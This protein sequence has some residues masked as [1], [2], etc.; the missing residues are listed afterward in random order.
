[1]SAL[2][3]VPLL[4]TK[5]QR[6]S[7]D[8]SNC[9]VCQTNTKERFAKPTERG[10]SSLTQVASSRK[11]HVYSR[12]WPDIENIQH[13]D[14]KWHPSCYASYTLKTYKEK[15]SPPSLSTPVLPRYVPQTRLSSNHPTRFNPEL[16]VICQRDRSH[17]SKA[18]TNKLVQVQTESGASRLEAAANRRQDEVFMRINGINL[19]KEQVKYHPYCRSAYVSERNITCATK[20]LFERGSGDGDNDDVFNNTLELLM[21]EISEPLRSGAALELSDVRARFNDLLHKADQDKPGNIDNRQLKTLLLRRFGDQLAFQ[22]PFSSSSSQLLYDRSVQQADVVNVVCQLTQ[23]QEDSSAHEELSPTQTVDSK[24]D[25]STSAAVLHAALAVKSDLRNLRQKNLQSEKVDLEEAAKF[26]PDSLYCLLKSILSDDDDD[27]QDPDADLHRAILNIGQDIAYQAS[28]RRLAPAKHVGIALAV[29]QATRSKTLVQ[30]LHAAGHCICYEQMQRIDTS[31]AKRQMCRFEE[32]QVTVSSN[33]TPGNFVQ[34]AADN[35]D[36][37]EKTLDGK[38]TFHA[39]QMAVF[40]NGSLDQAATTA[41][42]PS[43]GRKRVLKDVPEGF[44]DI[45]PA[46]MES[47]SKKLQPSFPPAGEL[48]ELCRVGQFN[49]HD[50]AWLVSRNLHHNHQV[51]PA[52][53]AYNQQMTAV[54]DTTKTVIGHMPIIRAPAH[55]F[56]TVWTVILRAKRVSQFLGQV[57]TVI[58]FDQA[59]YYKAKELTWLR[60]EECTKVIIRLGGFHTALNFLRCIGQHYADSG[61]KDIWMDSGLYSDCTAGKILEGKHWKRAVRAH[62]LTFE[63]LWRCLWPKLAECYPADKAATKALESIVT[64]FEKKDVQAATSLL[65]QVTTHMIQLAQH[66]AHFEDGCPENAM[67]V[68]WMQYMRMVSTLLS[69]IRAER[70]GNWSLHLSS[71]AEMLP[72]FSVYDHTN[73]ARWAPVYLLDMQ[74]LPT[75][76]PEVNMQFQAGNFGVRESTKPFSSL[77]TDQAL[78]HIN[79][80]GK[81]AGGLVGITKTDSALDRWSLTYT[82]R[83]HLADS[84]YKMLGVRIDPEGW[85]HVESGATR[86]KR[87]EE[88]VQKLVDELTLQCIFQTSGT[89]LI[90]LATKDVATPDITDSLLTAFKRGKQLASDYMDARL[91][92]DN[93]TFYDRL[94]KVKSKTFSDLYTVKTGCSKEST[95]KADRDLYRRLL[96]AVQSGRD[97]D[98]HGLLK[99]ELA[100]VPMS[101]ASLDGNLHKADKAPLRHI[102][103]DDLGLAQLPKTSRPTCVVIDAMAVVQAIGKPVGATTF[104]DLADSFSKSI[105]SHFKAATRVDVVFDQYRNN[106]IKSGTR[107]RR[108]GVKGRSIRRV[109]EG[110][111]VPLPTQWQGFISMSANKADLVQFLSQELMN[112]VSKVPSG[113]ELVV[114]GGFQD[115]EGVSSSSG[116]CVEHLQSSQEEADTRLALHA[117]EAALTGYR[118]TVICSK[119]TDVLVILLHFMNQLSPEV[120]MSTGTY[121]KPHFLPVH[122]IHQRQPGDVLES[123]LA[124]HAL[125]GCDTTSH[126]AGFGKKM[127]WKVYKDQPKLIVGLGRG[128]VTS[129]LTTKVEQF[130]VKLYS[131]KDQCSVN[132]LRC[133]LFYTKPAEKLPPTQDALVQHTHRAH[134]QTMV[135][136]S[137]LLPKPDLPAPTDHG[138]VEDGDC[139]KP[140]LTTLTAVPEA[141]VELVTCRCKKKCGSASCSCRKKKLPCTHA[142][143]CNRDDC[144]NIHN[145]DNTA[146]ELDSDSDDE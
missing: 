85:E 54:K 65:P 58:T 133:K 129:T 78:E 68:Y 111:T 88:D 130:V 77:P 114:A 23:Q 124:F 70:E 102:L 29:H 89:D 39:T 55:E 100:P 49:P 50:L 76:A 47:K 112:G 91:Q 110:R 104:G 4:P 53:T 120:W 57:H 56:D 6:L 146:V 41:S 59:L 97:V 38:G 86:L 80:I 105:L 95:I 10:I 83:A 2:R 12:L 42:L 24:P 96:T 142:C 87:D 71:L 28:H 109:I 134:Y 123:L 63:A 137:A 17:H 94:V 90:S 141:C 122:K 35:I 31:L 64:C 119:D 60:P 121:T 132:E 138:W 3:A 7:P 21:Q 66:L 67:L 115:G 45:S 48:M 52:W 128:L 101:L 75:T 126:F 14:V 1:M 113:C 116:R 16:C 98:I 140:V 19:V 117:A 43:P 18:G 74:H 103:E 44:H 93:S 61:L 9:I 99:Y 26:V 81:V 135:W 69:F 107:T 145:P 22:H 37:L 33:L 20:L 15:S 32:N 73:Y 139:L 36:I 51:I 62:K 144:Q 106:S 136:R 13:K 143:A 92:N 34:Y 27:D 40:Q 30:L 72:W 5:R 127:A 118:R 108:A 79:R 8:W 131:A 84:T 125:T 25:T 11:D 46:G 82:E